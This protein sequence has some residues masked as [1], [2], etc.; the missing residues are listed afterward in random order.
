[1]NEKEKRAASVGLV[2]AADYLGCHTVT[3][4]RLIK[5]KKLEA[6]KVGRDWRILKSVLRE[7]SRARSSPAA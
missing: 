4:R 1:M 5:D 6:F 2:V 3:V 7:F